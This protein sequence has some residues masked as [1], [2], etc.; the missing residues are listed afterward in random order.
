MAS[1]DETPYVEYPDASVECSVTAEAGD[2]S[3]YDRMARPGWRTVPADLIA[4]FIAALVAGPGER[5]ANAMQAIAED[6]QYGPV[7]L[8]RLVCA[9]EL[10]ARAFGSAGLLGGETHGARIGQF[11]TG[12]RSPEGLPDLLAA[13]RGEG[14]HAATD[15]AKTMTVE[16]RLGVLDALSHYVGTFTREAL[17]DP[18]HSFI[19]GGGR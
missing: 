13:L 14:L 9:A 17:S 6:E 11:I 5:R 2:E 4:E 10:T 7:H 8:V 3:D 15:V 18:V 1:M 12:D 16:Q 19:A